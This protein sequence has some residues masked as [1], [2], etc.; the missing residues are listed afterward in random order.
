MNLHAAL[1]LLIAMTLTSACS[2]IDKPDS[3]WKTLAQS[4]LQFIYKTIKENHPGP[5]DA[6]NPEFNDWLEKG[7]VD[8]AAEAKNAGSFDAYRFILL[9]YVKGFNDGHLSFWTNYE[10]SSVK[11]PGFIIAYRNGRYIVYHSE[12]SEIRK[13]DQLTACNN[14]KIENLYKTNVFPYKGL[15]EPE[16][17]LYRLAPY[18][19]IDQ[20]NPFISMPLNC[21]FSRGGK[22]VSHA[23]SYREKDQE[24]LTKWVS[25]AAFGPEGEFEFRV[26]EA[27]KYWVR[28]PTFAPQDEQ[29]KSI[30]AYI[31]KLKRLSKTK[32]TIVFDVR[33]NSGGSSSW[34]D[35]IV[36][37]LYGKEN[38]EKVNKHIGG[39]VSA[40]WRVSP[41][42]FKAIS[43]WPEVFEERFGPENETTLWATT[44][45]QRFEQA[46]KERKPTIKQDPE[47][48][49]VKKTGNLEL[50]SKNAFRGEI[51]LLTDGRCA[52]ACLDFAD[53]VLAMPNATHVGMETSA[54]TV[55]ME[56][57]VIDQLPSGLGSLYYPM[58]VYRNR[59]RGNR[60]SYKPKYLWS[61]E[62][63]DTEGLQNWIFNE[64]STTNT[65]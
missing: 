60:E 6:E 19:L 61:G 12:V 8:A 49:R 9:K 16:S 20:G 59:A 36:E 56:G 50:D 39:N 22:H 40:E 55:Y 11:W 25:E 54:D 63:S 35:M 15:P 37:S 46:L 14:K 13:G 2:T 10:K 17:K 58:K 7:H 31:H 34:G 4:D 57:N 27:D 44:F 5:I 32:A 43:N 65:K 62:M 21:Q 33:G 28:I 1:S 64:S 52:S 41:E 30:K 51:F 53:I 47:S 18:L 26:I 48:E 45:V 23:L 42:N 3:A 38:V 29:E 24:E